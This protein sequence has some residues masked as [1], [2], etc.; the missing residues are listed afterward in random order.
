[1]PSPHRRD[2]LRL[3]AGSA[4]PL[5]LGHRLHGQAPARILR[6]H[7]PENLES[8]FAALSGFIT[9]TDT[10]YVRSHFATPKI[11]RAAWKLR[12]EGAVEKPM[13]FT[14]DQLQKLA[15]VRVPLL[16]EC[17][18]NGRGYLVPP[19]R[20]VNW[21]LGAV[22]VAEW[23]GVPLVTLL[24]KVGVKSNAVEVVLEG[25][26]TGVPEGAPGP[27]AYARGLPL[28]KA[29]KPETMLVYGMNGKDLAPRHG[30]PL[31]AVIGGWYGMA[32]VKWLRRIVVTDKPFQGFWQAVDY[33]MYERV[34]GLPS[35]VPITE[36]MVKSQIARPALSET[37]PAGK[38]YRVFG[39]AWAGEAD[40]AKV[41]FSADAGKTWADAKLF[42][43]PVPFCWRLWEY[44]WKVPASP[45]RAVLMSRATDNR[46]RTQPMERDPDRRTYVIN[47]VL[48]IE[49]EIT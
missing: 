49:I 2:F 28:E 35:V 22:G 34:N 12:V 46:K 45:G 8:N 27:I 10:F 30:A 43:Q 23:T 38:S 11:D 37:V 40:V 6:S 3:A 24:E 4:L 19:A 17:A 48:P 13:E 20:G 16:L 33:T 21:Q 9:P 15:E 26:D 41:E 32:S 14:L 39:A 7:H 36:G 47:H 31:R 5:A 18:G 29:R 25:A 1:M 42:D 44:E